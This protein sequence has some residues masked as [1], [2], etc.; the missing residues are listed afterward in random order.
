MKCIIASLALLVMVA[1]SSQATLQVVKVVP[2]DLETPLFDKNIYVDETF[3]ETMYRYCNVN[4]INLLSGVHFASNRNCEGSDKE[5]DEFMT[6]FLKKKGTTLCQ[7]VRLLKF[8]KG[9]TTE[10]TTDLGTVTFHGTL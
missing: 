7:L 2:R 9:F 10:L 5:A 4:T 6:G 1:Y 3:C 8:T